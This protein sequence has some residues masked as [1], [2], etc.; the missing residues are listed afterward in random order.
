VVSGTEKGGSTIDFRDRRK[1]GI[2]T[3][4]VGGTKKG[5]GGTEK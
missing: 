5:V 4:E 2:S 3:E 1:Y